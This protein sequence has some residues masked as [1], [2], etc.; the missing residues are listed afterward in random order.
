MKKEDTKTSLLISHIALVA[1]FLKLLLDKEI[2]L[3]TA[4]VWTIAKCMGHGGWRSYAVGQS[5]D[6]APFIDQLECLIEG[7]IFCVQ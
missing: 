3:E 4:E 2:P 6:L 1:E 5:C 7:K